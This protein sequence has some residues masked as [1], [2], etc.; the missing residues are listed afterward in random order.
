LLLLTMVVVCCICVWCLL[1]TLNSPFLNHC[2]LVCL[3]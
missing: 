1:W 3:V 2:I